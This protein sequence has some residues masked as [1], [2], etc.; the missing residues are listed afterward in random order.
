MINEIKRTFCRMKTSMV[1]GRTPFINDCEYMDMQKIN[2]R[3]DFRE[4]LKSRATQYTLFST[5]YVRAVY[6]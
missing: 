3:V 4:L 6:K 5:V 2:N 1:I